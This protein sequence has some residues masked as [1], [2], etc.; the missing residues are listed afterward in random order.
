MHLHSKL[1][2]T[3][4]GDQSCAAYYSLMKGYAD[5]MAATG[6]H[7]EDEDVICYILAGLNFKYNP[8]VESFT[9]KTDPQTLNDLYSQLL[10]AEARVES[11]KEQ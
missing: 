2:S 3:K 10:M 1:S 8:F 4:K 7:L 11:Q 6:K 9:A 5:E